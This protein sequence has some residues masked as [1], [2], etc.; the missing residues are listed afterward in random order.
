MLLSWPTLTVV[1][2]YLWT[3]ANICS[4]LEPSVKHF[5][6]A[7]GKDVVEFVFVVKFRQ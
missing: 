5:S 2:L 6:T 4:Q 1:Y 7:R 3:T